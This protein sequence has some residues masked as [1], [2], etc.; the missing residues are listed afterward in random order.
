[1]SGSG[2][3]S[4]QSPLKPHLVAGGG[5]I[6]GEIVDLRKDLRSVLGALAAITV[7]EFTNVAAAGAAL[8]RVATAVVEEEVVLE[9]SDLLAPGLAILAT[10]PRNL[11]F[12]TAGNT[13]ADAPATATIVGTYRG[14]PQT[15]TVNLAQTATIATG[16]K[17]FSTVESITF[18]AGDGTDCTVAIGI[19]TGIGVGE[20]PKARAGGVNLIREI[21]VGSLVT[22]GA[23]T[24]AGLYTPSS[25]PNATNDYAVYYEYDPLA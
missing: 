8:L 15:E 13:P 19:G 9:A 7:D 21:A 12:T 5:G 16:T 6:A 17:P 20:V 3:F 4:D 18:P 11:T 14:L 25:A 22:N 2:L 23:L 24:A 10:Y 1:M